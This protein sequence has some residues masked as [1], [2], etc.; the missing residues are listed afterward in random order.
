MGNY[1]QTVG[2]ALGA[3]ML[4]LILGPMEVHAA[5]PPAGNE[6]DISQPG[7]PQADIEL[8]VD[9]GT[10]MNVDVSPDGHSIVF[11]LLGDIYS[12]P[13]TGGNATLI[14]GGA[15]MQ[16]AATFSLDGTRLLYL[17][18]ASGS[19]NLWIC[20]PDG[21]GARQIT[22]ESV[23][24][25]MGP[26]WT[27]DG[28]GVAASKIDSTYPRVNSSEIRVFD[29]NGAPRG[30]GRVLVPVPQNQR[31]VQEVNFSR[32]GRYAFYTQRLTSPIVFSDANH[33]NFGIERRDLHSGAVDELLSGFGGAIA[34]EVSQDGRRLAFVRRVMTRTVLFVLDLA[35]HEQRPVYNELD[36][37]LQADW[38]PHGH[39]YPHFAW[40]PDNRHVAIWAKGKLFNIDM[41]TGAAAQIPFNVKAHHQIIQPVRFKHEMAPTQ[42][43]V[44]AVRNLAVSPDRRTLVFTAVGRLWRKSLPDGSPVAFSKTPTSQFDPA[45]ANDGRRTAFVEWDDAKGSALIVS[46]SNGGHP[47]TIATSP[48][49]IRQPQFS[50]D[51][52]RVVYRVQH[53][54][55][56]MGGD[57]AKPGI[58]W[59]ND[60]GGASHFVADGDDAPMFSPDGQRIYYV[61]QDY[62]ES[63]VVQHLWSATLEGYDKREHVRTPNADTSDLRLSPDLRWIAF[64]DRQQYFIARYHETGAALLLSAATSDIPVLALTTRGGFGLTWAADSSAVTWS[65]GADLFEASVGQRSALAAA[66]SESRMAPGSARS[67][68]LVAERPFA[69]IGLSLPADVPQGAVAFVNARLI[70]MRGDEVIDKGTVLVEGNRIT[71]VGSSDSVAIPRNAK[72]IDITGKTLMPGLIDSHGHI[73]CCYETGT[74]PQKQPLR[75][76]ALSYGVTTNFD[77]YPNELTSYEST[78]AT[79]AGLTVGPRWIGTGA[80]IYGRAQKADFLYVPIETYADAQNILARKQALGGFAIKSYKQPA[81]YQRQML[82]KAARATGINV[83]VEGES[84]FYNNITFVLDGHTNLEHNLP[85]ANYYDDVVQLMSKAGAH[86]TP[87]LVVAFGELFGENYLYQTTQAW[88]EPKVATFVQQTLSG[89]SPL[90]TPYGAPPYVRNM[91]SIH[92]ADEIYD[93]G[94]RSVARSIKKLDDAG[95]VINAGSHGQLA[96]LALHWE[97]WLLSQ[98]G[99]SNLRVLRTATLNGANSLGVDAELGS[100]EPGKLADLIVLDR[101]PLEDIHN[102]SSVHYTMVNGRLY[103]AATMNEIGNYNRPRGRFYWEV[104]R[105]PHIDWNSSWGGQ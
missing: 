56:S 88:K 92:A 17:S 86:N 60:S 55:V 93:I 22:H 100:I 82:I 64:R 29:V 71:A 47:K 1:R 103:D 83:V 61:V 4:G 7:E 44:R 69:S 54:D 40:F 84:H 13:A 6:W 50:R 33:I 81:R 65:L 25:L 97:M 32:D 12:I 62:S 38:V 35:T 51:G 31:D 53:A 26:A 5:P 27:A 79:L 76:A 72:V 99:M 59:V 101:N 20:N 52:K 28:Q 41:D 78:E 16:R 67:P 37:D 21:S 19:D 46:D 85:V 74:L 14:A 23:D 24:L 45:F 9:Q 68:A 89:Y 66:G 42:V 95:V 10:W 90:G 34:S 70:T 15:A 102:T 105:N 73:D 104:H 87:T 91:T 57:R 48:G 63:S 43:T 3:C 96:G 11:D 18:D 49:V 36:R 30:G 2:A 75:Y 98:G 8:T 77:P 58:F 94:F 39:Y 80:A